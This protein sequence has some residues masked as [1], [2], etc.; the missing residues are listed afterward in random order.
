MKAR[1]IFNYLGDNPMEGTDLWIFELPKENI[2]Y[3]SH[4]DLRWKMFFDGDANKK[5]VW[6]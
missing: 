6:H 3:N 5:R 2:L 4:E 1:F